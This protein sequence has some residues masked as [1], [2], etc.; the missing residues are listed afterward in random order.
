M[1]GEDQAA[2][3]ATQ[4]ANNEK[5]I[6]IRVNGVLRKS[7]LFSDIIKDF[8]NTNE[9]FEKYLSYYSDEYRLHHD[10]KDVEENGE[11][12]YVSKFRTPNPNIKDDKTEYLKHIV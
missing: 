5:S 6:N 11:P 12:R 2:A 7:N 1:S 8:P 9:A 3:I 10:I 4:I